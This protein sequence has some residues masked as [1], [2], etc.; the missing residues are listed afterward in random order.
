[1]TSEIRKDYVQE[2]YVIIAPTRLARH[3]VLRAAPP[4]VTKAPCVFCPERL[5][6]EPSLL[7][8][9]ESGDWQLKVV[10]N[11]FPAVSLSNR[12]AYGI[13]EVVIETP[14]HGVHLEALPVGHIA[15]LLHVYAERT[16]AILKHKKIRYVLG[17][18]NAGGNAGATVAHAHSQLFATALMPPHV[19]DKQMRVRAYYRRT[20]RCVYCDVVKKERKGPRLVYED[21][22]VIVFTPFA[23]MHAYEVWIMPR[24]HLD[25]I[26]L[27]HDDER[28]AFAHSMQRMLGKIVQ[29]QLPYNY[30]FHEVPRDTHQH[31]YIKITPRGSVWAGVEIG[32]G[33]IINPVSPEIAAEYYRK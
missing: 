28:L 2:Q 8:C 5:R 7:S 10:P 23:S 22:H 30:Y 20:G 17:F 16:A 24:R 26:T 29:L 27:L 12:R 19:A 4:A 21:A 11:K 1:M 32:S 9:P 15:A 13:Q 25:N 6:D 31:F 14:L 3:T 18:K 33:F